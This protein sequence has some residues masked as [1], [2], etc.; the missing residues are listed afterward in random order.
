M[1]Y[2]DE[3]TNCR[4]APNGR[5]IDTLFQ[6]EAYLMRGRDAQNQWIF[7][8]GPNGRLCWAF[9][10]LFTFTHDGHESDLSEIPLDWLPNILTPTATFTPTPATGGAPAATKTSAP[11]PPQCNDGID[12]DGDGLIDMADGRCKDPTD[13]SES[14]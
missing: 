12:N 13:N 9:A 11:P 2:P 7:L 4:E 10:A 14:S 6:G 1:A 5:I 3:D 8:R